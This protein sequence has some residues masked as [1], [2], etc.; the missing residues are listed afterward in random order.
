MQL[1]QENDLPALAFH[2]GAQCANRWVTGKFSLKPPPGDR[3]A[4]RKRNCRGHDVAN[5]HDYKSPP[6]TEE[7][8]APYSKDAARKQEDITECKKQRIANRCPSAPAHDALL[9]R[10]DK[11]D[12][13]NEARQGDSQR[14]C[15]HQRSN[16]VANRAADLGHS[17]IVRVSH[18]SRKSRQFKSAAFCSTRR[19]KLVRSDD[20]ESRGCQKL[21]V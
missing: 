15:Q 5:K 12:D 20:A 21:A 14:N 1:A 13:R 6:Q 18:A 3:P 4:Q 17:G 8:T 10:F 11:I 2:G 9:Q 19:S 16:L 7:K